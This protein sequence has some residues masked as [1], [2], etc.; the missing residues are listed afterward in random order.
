MV[1]FVLSIYRGFK[2]AIYLRRAILLTFIAGVAI[3]AASQDGLTVESATGTVSVRYGV[4]ED[5]EVAQ[6]GMVIR[7]EDTIRTGRNGTLVLKRN[8]GTM[9]R[10]PSETML[11]GSDF[12][13]IDRNELLLLLAAEDMLSVPERSEEERPVPQTTVLHGELR[14]SDTEETDVSTILETVGMR[15]NGAAYLANQKYTGSAILKVRETLR[16]YP[17][18]SY[19]VPAML[20]AAE[21]LEGLTLFEEAVKYYRTI[22]ESGPDEATRQKAEMRIE[23]LS[24]KL[25]QE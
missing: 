25:R 12:R 9:Y 4:A 5:W 7:P 6:R 11:D 8:D 24:G 14:G 23:A 1:G 20:F 21:S 19:R 10:I 17:Y 16:L 2:N 15:M 22:L 3:P 13:S 18:G